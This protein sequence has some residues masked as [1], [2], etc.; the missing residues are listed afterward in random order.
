M[1]LHWI[2]RE[3]NN[4]L[5]LFFSGWGSGYRPFKDLRLPGTDILLLCSYHTGGAPNWADICRGYA[6]TRVLGWSMGV[7]QAELHLAGAGLPISAASAVNGTLVPVSDSCGIPVA[8]YQ[9]TIDSF[10]ERNYR[11]FAQRMCARKEIMGAY[12][13]NCPDREI[14]EL[15]EELRYHQLQSQLYGTEASKLFGAAYIGAADNIFPPANLLYFWK[16]KAEVHENKL[17][18]FPFYS[19]ESLEYFFS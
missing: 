11:K 12:L 9:A 1:E 3:N 10:S 16:G 4:K 8:Q 5:L 19:V 18:H 13:D 15:K 7:L 14:A 17:P 2:R 6:D